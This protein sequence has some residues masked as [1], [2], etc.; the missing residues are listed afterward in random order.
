MG[1]G[2]DDVMRRRSRG[3]QEEEEEE[4]GGGR[5]RGTAEPSQT[6]LTLGVPGAS[7]SA[8]PHPP[9][10]WLGPGSGSEAGCSQAAF[11]CETLRSNPARDPVL[12]VGRVP[13]T[14][15]RR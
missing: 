3:G 7:R 1:S 15:R 14:L 11:L 5:R 10:A 4:G 6:G 9:G 2:G 8:A 13:T 12:H